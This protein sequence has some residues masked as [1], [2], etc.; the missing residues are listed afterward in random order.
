MA[1]VAAGKGRPPKPFMTSG[2]ELL[3]AD[4]IWDSN[5]GLPADMRA[6]STDRSSTGVRDAKKSPSRHKRVS[7]LPDFVPPQLC[8]SLERPPNGPGWAHEITLDGYH[9]QMRVE[10]GEAT[11]HARNGLTWTDRLPA[12]A[13]ASGALPDY[14]VD[15]EIVAL[16][17]NG[18]PSFPVLQAALSEGRTNN[19][20]FFV[21]DLLFVEGED[22][23]GR[24]L[25]P[26]RTRQSGARLTI[27]RIPLF[28]VVDGRI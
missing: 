20:V 26:S 4:A 16:D 24:T 21:F 22:L 10:N 8:R 25:E 23:R 19:L 13:Q 6:Q 11:M 1:A 18:A 9:M 3:R 12:I 17:G 27:D 28:Q 14:I 5:S 15:G 2:S 7:R